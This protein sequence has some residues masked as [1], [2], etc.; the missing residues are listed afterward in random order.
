MSK[1]LFTK[2][3][4]DKIFGTKYFLGT[5]GKKQI[6]LNKRLEQDNVWDCGFFKKLSKEL[7]PLFSIYEANKSHIA[8]HKL[9]SSHC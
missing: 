8:L 1:Q 9:Y 3:I 6:I 4:P 7:N 5:S 2:T